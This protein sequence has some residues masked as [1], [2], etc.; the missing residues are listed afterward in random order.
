MR[1]QRR[2]VLLL[3]AF[4]AG[5]PIGVLVATLTNSA[6]NAMVAMALWILIFFAVRIFWWDSLLSCPHCRVPA[7]AAGSSFTVGTQCRN[8]HREY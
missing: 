7:A 8:C 1:M 6:E 2:V 5:L 3:A 4:V